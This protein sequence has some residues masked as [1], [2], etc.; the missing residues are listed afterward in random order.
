MTG[1]A[2]ENICLIHTLSAYE[3]AERASAIV[4]DSVIEQW[5]KADCLHDLLLRLA[6]RCGFEPAGRHRHISTVEFAR[7]RASQ[8]ARVG[9]QEAQSY[10][11]EN[12]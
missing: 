9:N 7:Q 6:I 3:S 1:S 2:Q 5:R 11:R 10:L 4:G 8:L 12:S